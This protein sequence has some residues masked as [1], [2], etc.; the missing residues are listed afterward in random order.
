M[1]Y[2]DP[3][4]KKDLDRQVKAVAKEYGVKLTTRTV[5]YMT[6]NIT[7]RQS[8]YAFKNTVENYDGQQVQR[9]NINHVWLKDNKQLT[10]EEK[11]FI[12]KL[13]NIVFSKE[14]GYYDHTDAQMDYFHTAWYLD[15]ELG[16]YDKPYVQI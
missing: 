3:A 4:K 11:E 6:Y 9:R 7:L 5:S 14:N 12:T 1:A 10:E 13:K 15:I 16:T 8:K 2:L